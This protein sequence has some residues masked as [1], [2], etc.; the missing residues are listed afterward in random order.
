VIGSEE[1]ILAMFSATF[2][3]MEILFEFMIL[4]QSISPDMGKGF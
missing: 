1:T 2:A 4:G 3:G